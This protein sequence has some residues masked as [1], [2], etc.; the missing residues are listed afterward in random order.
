VTLAFF[1]AGIVVRWF[2]DQFAGGELEE[3]RHTGRDAYDLLTR[4]LSDR[5]SGICFTPHFIGSGNPTWNVNATGAVVGLRPDRTRHDLFK[6]LLEGIACELA[7]NIGVLERLVGKIDIL[8]TFGGGAK[9]RY[10]MQM[11]ADITGKRIASMRSPEAVCLGA[12]VLAGVAAGVY[13]DT[14]EGACRAAE[15][16]GVYEPNQA[17]S[18][19]YADQVALYNRLYPALAGG[20]MFS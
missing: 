13:A 10:W 7:T 4:E 6:A 17:R 5:P 18:A 16:S 12:A 19:E 20:G 3:E 15:F 9:S 14:A 1:P 11:R 8:R 2:R